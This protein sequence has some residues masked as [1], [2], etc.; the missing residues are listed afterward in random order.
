MDITR[1]T[2]LALAAVAVVAA[3]ASSW[4]LSQALASRAQVEAVRSQL[5]DQN[6]AV[7][8][9]RAEFATYDSQ[10]NM[11]VLLSSVEG[12][13]QALVQATQTQAHESAA[14]AG[15]SLQQA[16]RS[17]SDPALSAA[18]TDLAG[19][20]SQYQGLATR[21]DQALAVKDT[22]AAARLQTIDNAT[23]S[24]RISKALDAAGARSHELTDAG[25][26]SLS[27]HQSL[28]V[29]TSIG[30]GVAVMLALA[31]ISL[32]LFRWLRPLRDVEH[33]LEELASGRLGT[34]LPK[35]SRPTDDEVGRMR[36]A[37]ERAV[38]QLR[39]TVLGI[40]EGMSTLAAATEQLAANSGVIAESAGSSAAQSRSMSESYRHVDGSFAELAGAAGEFGTSI[41]DISRS[42][43]E[44]AAIAAAAVSQAQTTIATVERLGRSSAEITGVVD[45][46]DQVAAQTNLLALNATIE[47]ARAGDAGKGFAVVATEVKALADQTAGATREIG[48]R[49]T[50]IQQDTEAAVAAISGITE[51][52]SQISHHQASIAGAVEEQAVTAQQMQQNIAVAASGASDLGGGVNA[53][54]EAAAAAHSSVA[55]SRQASE[56]LTRLSSRLLQL[57]SHFDLGRVPSDG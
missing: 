21:V 27:E 41:Q 25:L 11:L 15:T 24:D 9:L 20:I 10:L 49:I 12:T 55:E 33:R 14:A 29:T 53:V 17:S 48:V 3:A 19:G 34:G 2:T 18:L 36:R 38:D 16:R 52:I 26:T 45:L 32:L 43:S 30:L 40:Q 31:T 8:D 51:V 35:Q 4:T 7:A 46:I 23:A 57:V 56:D 6:Q 37:T 54:A 47:A 39:M 1:R 44:A 13:Q 5:A 42:S 50:Q 28:V 22:A